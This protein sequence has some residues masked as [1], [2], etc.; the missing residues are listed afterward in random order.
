VVAHTLFFNNTM[1]SD[2]SMMGAG[3]LTGQDPGFSAAPNPGV[4]GT[5]ETVDDDFSGLLLQSGSP[6]IDRG[7]TQ[8]TAVNGELIP[9]SE[10][11]GYIGAAPDLGWR[12]FG[13]PIV[14]TPT[15]SPLP[16]PTFAVSPTVLSPTFT[17]TF[18]PV[19]PTPTVVTVTPLPTVTVVTPTSSL[20][21]ITLT[22]P[23]PSLPTV[24]ITPTTAQ[25]SLLSVTPNSAQANTTVNV[26]LSGTA[27]A[28][29]ATVRFEGAQGTAPQVTGTQVVNANTI[30]ITVTA[31][32]DPG[33]AT[34]V[35]DVRVTNPNNTFVVLPDAFTVT[36]P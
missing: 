21:T 18:T 14:V 35:W 23:A 11:T 24:T 7:V 4:D 5:W 19:V 13:S 20:P 8:F 26:T 17:L 27:F 33:A 32:V 9:A 6:A 36:V 34:Q 31:T 16:S 29:G 2:Q 25:L 1:D 3:I 12:E 30:V 22:A 15:A 28:N 10:I